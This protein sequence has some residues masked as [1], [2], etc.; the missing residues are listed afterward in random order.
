[1]LIRE[2]IK[3]FGIPLQARSFKIESLVQKTGNK[4]NR[5]GLKKKKMSS[6]L[7]VGKKSINHV[8]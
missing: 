4:P 5:R 1:M 7:K 2:P 6:T 3:V 8:D